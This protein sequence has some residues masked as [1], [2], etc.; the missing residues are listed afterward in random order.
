VVIVNGLMKSGTHA[1]MALLSGMGLMRVPGTIEGCGFGLRVVGNHGVNLS[2]P[3]MIPDNVFIL[4]HIVSHHAERL[5]G[6]KVI[7]VF[8]D[9]RN[10]LISYCRHRKRVDGLEVSTAEALASYWGTPFVPLYRAFLRW[11]SLSVVLRYE[12]L[13]A[14][15][16]G[17]GEAIYTAAE[18][19]WNTR[20]GSPSDWTEDW[21]QG[22]HRAWRE[23][24]GPELL[25]EA[26][27]ADA[28]GAESRRR[29]A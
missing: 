7:T 29:S 27:Y 8:R 9:P 24:G 20:T 21:G 26:G 13:P 15:M 6:F 17:D 4:G 3:R 19:H 18:R 23:A 28:G 22:D 16:I 10:C 11:R 12:E 14:A 5:E 1:V 25:H 2:A